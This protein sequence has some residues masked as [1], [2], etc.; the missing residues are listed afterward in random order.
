MFILEADG[1][2]QHMTTLGATSVKSRKLRPQ[3]A[4][5]S[6][7]FTKK[8]LVGMINVNFFVTTLRW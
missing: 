1:L 4:Q 8:I 3:F 6:R 2:Q 7:K 5:A